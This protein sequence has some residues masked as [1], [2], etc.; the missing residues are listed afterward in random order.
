MVL[1]Y[2]VQV[3]YATAQT[4]GDGMMSL[5]ALSRETRAPA[6]CCS[7]GLNDSHVHLYHSPQL[8]T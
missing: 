2:G 8:I 3:P 1:C 6:G 7:P 5:T 4:V